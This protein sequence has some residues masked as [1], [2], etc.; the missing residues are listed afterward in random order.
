MAHNENIQKKNALFIYFFSQPRF[1]VVVYFLQ[2]KE[3]RADQS[4]WM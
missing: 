4:A 1:N 3:V 2:R